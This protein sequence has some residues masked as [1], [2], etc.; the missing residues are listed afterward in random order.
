[1]VEHTLK[2]VESLPTVI[3]IQEDPAG[4]MK[5]LPASAAVPLQT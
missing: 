5:S 4:Q 2:L 3:G 1:M